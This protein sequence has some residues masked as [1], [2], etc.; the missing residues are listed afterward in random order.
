MLE[1]DCSLEIDKNLFK[2][3]EL[4]RKILTNIGKLPEVEKKE[5]TSFS[6]FHLSKTKNIPSEIE[7]ENP[8]S[9]PFKAR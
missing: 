3:R 1:P 5:M 9:T 6:E 7:K 2:A 8:Y 4:N